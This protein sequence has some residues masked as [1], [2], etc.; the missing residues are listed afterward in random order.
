MSNNEIVALYDR[1]A[2]KR[3]FDILRTGRYLFNRIGYTRKLARD[4]E[5]KLELNRKDNLL[6]IGCNIGIY[7]RHLI[8]RV[9]HIL[10]VDAGEMIIKKAQLKNESDRDTREGSNEVKKNI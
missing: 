4:I 7:H 1:I 6:D 9:N 2:A 5:E 10:G 8:K 3:T